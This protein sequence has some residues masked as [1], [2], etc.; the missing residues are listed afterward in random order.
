MPYG[1]LGSPTPVPMP[2]SPADFDPRTIPGLIH[3]WDGNDVSTLTIADGSV[4]Q[5][6]SK[7]GQRITAS[8]TTPNNR[9]IT[10]TVNGRTAVLFDGVNDGL[11]FSGTARTDETWIIVAAQT[12]DQTGTRQFISDAASGFGIA[13]ARGASLRI[14][15]TAWG[16]FTDGVGRIRYGYS[17][18]PATLI[19][20]DVISVVRSAAGGGFLFSGGVQRASAINGSTFFTTSGSVTIDRLGF[21]SS[22]G[23]QLQGWIGEVLCWNRPLSTA[24]R[25]NSERYLG[26]KWGVYVA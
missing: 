11:I 13:S 21:Y 12:A 17:S 7:W 6:L 24:E 14:L 9:P 26:K 15:D 16:N 1:L 8:Q 18:N 20:P 22:A 4:A 19:G 3:W 23:L 25:L 2:G 10:T 5:W